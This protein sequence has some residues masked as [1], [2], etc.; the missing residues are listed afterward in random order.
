VMLDGQSD[1]KLTTLLTAPFAF[2]SGPL[3]ALY[4][5]TGAARPTATRTDLPKGQRAGLLTL[6]GVMAVY[7]HPDQS[8]PVGRGYL[9]SDRLLCITPPPAPDDV[10]AMLPPPN[11]NQTTR[12][13]LEAHR[14]NPTCSSCH[15]LMDPYGLTFENYDAIGRYRMTEGTRPVDASGKA[16]PGGVG[17]VTNAVDLM[18][19]LAVNQTVRDCLAKQWFRYAL[20]RE[21]RAEDKGTLDAA[22]SAFGKA[23]YKMSDLVVGLATSSGFRYRSPIALP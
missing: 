6:A 3:Q 14:T 15:G 2:P 16:L 12:E 22:L 19:K 10:V 17:D 18:G 8:G 20:G 9:V 4:G 23:D 1:G 21:D 11:P 13:R 5:L 7:A